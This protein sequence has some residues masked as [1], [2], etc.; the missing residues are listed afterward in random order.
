MHKF[1]ALSLGL[2]CLG[3]TLSEA[4]PQALI[5]SGGKDT[6]PTGKEYYFDCELVYILERSRGLD[7]IV[8]AED[9]T[10]KFVKNKSRLFPAF[11]HE[12][13]EAAFKLIQANL[14]PGDPVDIHISD[15]GAPAEEGDDAWNGS[16]VL[17]QESSDTPPWAVSHRE[18]K[19]LIEQYIPSTSLVRLVGSYCF[20]GGLHQ[21]SF[22]L[23]NVER[24]LRSQPE[25]DRAGRVNDSVFASG[26]I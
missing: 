5:I 10:W 14:N 17:F 13:L 25:E 9:G 18:L 19:N 11:S 6:G 2:A 20:S 7:P 1:L 24:R 21:I 15:H 12:N 8:V 26:S 3:G 23:P 22:Q 4:A 16:F